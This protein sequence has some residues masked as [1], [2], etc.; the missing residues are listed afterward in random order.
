VRKLF[1]SSSAEEVLRR[2]HARLGLGGKLVEKDI[3]SGEET[4][5]GVFIQKLRCKKPDLEKSDRGDSK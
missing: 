2:P 1:G 4:C 5:R 3:R